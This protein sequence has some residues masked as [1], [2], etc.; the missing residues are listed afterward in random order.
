MPNECHGKPERRRH[1]D[2]DCGPD[3]LD[4]MIQL[5]PVMDNWHRLPE[6]VRAQVVR[7]VTAALSDEPT[8]DVPTR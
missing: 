7:I 2:A 3:W 8:D 4:R 5:M 1:G 6:A